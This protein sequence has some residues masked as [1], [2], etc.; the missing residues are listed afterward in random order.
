[1]CTLT[2]YFSTFRCVQQS[3][4]TRTLRDLG[5]SASRKM[6]AQSLVREVAMESKGR[7]YIATKAISR[8]VLVF[9][10]EPIAFAVTDGKTE[11]VCHECLDM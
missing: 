8:G 2:A 10:E 6:A 1:M 11:K 9:E 3:E 5:S 4:Q 7:G